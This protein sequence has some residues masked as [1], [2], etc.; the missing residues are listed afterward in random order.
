MSLECL[1]DLTR[2]QK[3]VN[4]VRWSPDGKLLASGDDES[5]IIV[6]QLK[7]G[8]SGCGGGLFD[9]DHENK[10]N[11]VVYKMIRSHLDDVYDLSWSGCG[12][13]LLSG[14][15]DNAAIITNVHKNN[16]VR[17]FWKCYTYIIAVA[18]HSFFCRL[19]IFLTVEATSKG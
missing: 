16:K 11:W 6:W 18:F 2:H 1:C 9:D 8:D 19:P 13:F 4:I 15:V 14:S 17:G 12:Q 5:V 10:E 7:P 3:A